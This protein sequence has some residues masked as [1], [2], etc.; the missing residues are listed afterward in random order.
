VQELL[1]ADLADIELKK[2][3]KKPVPLGRVPVK[4]I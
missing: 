3:N 1:K 4:K 2:S